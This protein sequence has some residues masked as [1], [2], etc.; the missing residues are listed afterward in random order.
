MLPQYTV[1]W[2]G[3]QALC[4]VPQNR[5]PPRTVLGPSRL[6]RDRDGGSVERA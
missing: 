4:N 1:A 6:R 2:E 5:L 3:T